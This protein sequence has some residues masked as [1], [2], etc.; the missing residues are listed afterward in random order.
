MTDLWTKLKSSDKPIVLYGMGNGAQKLIDTLAKY[1]ICV[2]GVFASDGFVRDKY[3]CGFKIKS[4]AQVRRE[5]GDIIVLTAFGTCR[6]EVINNIKRISGECELYAPDLPVYGDG[7]FDSA[8]FTK[9]RS[10]LEFVRSKL[11]DAK[12]RHVFDCIVN[13]KL[14]GD[15]GQL[16]ECESERSEAFENI[17]KLGRDEIFVDLGAYRGDTVLEFLKYAGGYKRIF[18]VEPDKKSYSKLI[19]NI[20]G[21]N[22]FCLNAAIG[23]KTGVTDFEMN[24]GR[25]SHLSSNGT[26]VEALTVDGILNGAPATYIKMD[27]EGAESE[28]I[29]GAAQT[30]IEHKPRMRIAGYHRTEDIYAIVKQVLEIRDDY[31]V[32]MRHHPYIPAWDTDFYFI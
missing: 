1:G 23:S 20:S 31:K 24:G 2:C 15:I 29:K 3:F 11:C 16:F 6:A 8:Y 4:Y 17:L 22:I 25:N 7:I 28:A 13:Y 5:F 18:A 14:S 9:H 19:Q 27:V 12:S 26:K 10:E 21:D 30:I 32:Y